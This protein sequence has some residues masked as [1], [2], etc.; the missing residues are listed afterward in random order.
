[1]INKRRIGAAI[2]LLMVIV[3]LSGCGAA[4]PMQDWPGITVADGVVYAI[5]GTTQQ[6]TMLD[7]ATGAAK[8]GFM[9]DDVDVRGSTLYWSPVAIGDEAAFVGFGADTKRYFALYAFNPDTGQKLWSVPSDD[10]IL[11][12][13]VYGDGTVYFGTSS[14]TIYAVDT[15]SQM[16]KPGWPVVTGDAIWGTPLLANGRLYVPSMDHNLYCL[17]GNS[18]QVLWQFEFGGAVASSPSPSDGNLYQGA[19]D[20]RLYAL[21][22]DSGQPVEGFDFKATNWI[23]SE[24]LVSENR[25]YVTTLDGELYALDATTGQ[26]QPGYPYQLPSATDFLRAGPVAAGDLV[27]VASAEGRV[28]AVNA[29]TGQVA[30]QWPTGTPTSQVLTTPVVAD[31]LVYFIL[32]N[33][34]V[35]ALDAST[36]AQAPAGWVYTPPAAQN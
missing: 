11:A 12:T 15:T 22:A 7:A 9:P 30:W 19:F 1:M 13:P 34:Q 8:G 17:D 21:G 27:I 20:A 14:G 25:I 10:L 35:Y 31:G 26:V 33:G 29:A 23:W 18:G 3:V 6:V 32:M 5:T 2:G 24:A 28:V 36:G 16:V 4:M